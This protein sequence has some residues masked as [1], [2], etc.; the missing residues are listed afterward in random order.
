M[1]LGLDLGQTI[2]WFKAKP[3][4]PCQHG[5]F[6]LKNTT[7]LGL[8]LRSSDAFFAEVLEGVTA[9]GVE[10]PFLGSDYYPARK[11]LALLGHVYYHANTR[12]IAASMIREYPVATAKLTLAGHGKAEKW[13]MIEAAAKMG[14]ED[15][16]EHAADALAQWCCYVHGPRESLA[17]QRAK[18]KTSKGRSLMNTGDPSVDGLKKRGLV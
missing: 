7:D 13:K 10:Q 3:V 6:T 15:M 2:G 16:G 9:I 11:L 4:G 18:A 17:A 12:G 8:W 1:I 5:Q 14:H